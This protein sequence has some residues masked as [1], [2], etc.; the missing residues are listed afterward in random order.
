[1]RTFP[2]LFDCHQVGCCILT[3]PNIT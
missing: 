2:I 1:M 3:W